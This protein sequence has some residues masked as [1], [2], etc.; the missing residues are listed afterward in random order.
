MRPV[1]GNGCKGIN[2]YLVGNAE[3]R[4]MVRFKYKEGT[5]WTQRTKRGF[6]S[7]QDAKLFKEKIDK[8]RY[9][10][11]FYPDRINAEFFRKSTTV[12]RLPKNWKVIPGACDNACMPRTGVYFIQPMG[13]GLVKVGYTKDIYKRF[14]QIQY[15]CP[16]AL[17]VLGV[18]DATPVSEIGLHMHFIDERHHGEWFL[19]QGRVRDFILEQG[20][21]FIDPV[22]T[23]TKDWEPKA[24][25]RLQ[26]HF[27]KDTEKTKSAPTL[28]GGEL[29]VD[30]NTQVIDKQGNNE[31]GEVREWPIRTVSKTVNVDEIPGFSA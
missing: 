4:W 29:E 9:E 1:N 6:M 22:F 15:Q 23:Y 26:E 5:K 25:E 21:P 12:K 3:R 27:K 7:L 30:E 31:N 18:L 20:F 8:L 2:E 19:P 11:R 24:A 17:K 10:S 13:G 14:R 28:L 16:V